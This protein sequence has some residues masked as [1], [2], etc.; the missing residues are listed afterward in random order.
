METQVFPP[1]HHKSNILIKASGLHLELDLPWTG[2]VSL[3]DIVPLPSFNTRYCEADH[4]GNLASHFEAHF[5]SQIALRRIC[6]T[7]HNN[8]N[9]CRLSHG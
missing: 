3:E 6:A 7:A 1:M 9:E 2:V 5:A 8:I 4:N